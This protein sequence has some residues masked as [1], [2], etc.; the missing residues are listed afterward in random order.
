MRMRTLSV[1]AIVVLWGALGFTVFAKQTGLVDVPHV[2]SFGSSVDPQGLPDSSASDT[3]T[4]LDLCAM[5]PKTSDESVFELDGR[6]VFVSDENGLSYIYESGRKTVQAAAE[7]WKD[8]CGMPST[9]RVVLATL[10]SLSLEIM[11]LFVSSVV[12]FLAKS[13]QM[14]NESRKRER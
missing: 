2:M 12:I 9:V 14:E 13:A 8:T 4:E 3:P 5:A 7:Y 6:N 10:S 11:L 1:C